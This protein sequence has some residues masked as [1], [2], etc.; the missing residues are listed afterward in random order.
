MAMAEANDPHKWLEE[1]LGDEPLAWVKSKNDEVIAAVGDP[2]TTEAYKRILAIL[3]SK[4]KIPNLFRIGGPDG[5]FYNF[6]QDDKHVQGIWRKTT[7]ASYKSGSPEW[8][9]VIDVDAL[10]PPTTDT[11]KTWVWHGSTLLDDGPGTSVDRAIIA[12]S[13]GGSDAD[14]R[15]EF[16]LVSERFIDASEGGF[17]MPTAA[18]TQLGWRSRNEVLVGT[19]FG[20]DGSTLTDSGYPRVVK[21][22][23]RGTPIEAAEV[24]FEGEQTDVAASQYAYHDRGFVHEFQLR[25]ITFYTSKYR[26]RLLTVD[27][28]RNTSAAAETTPFADVHI[29][30]DAELGTFGNAALV[31]LRSDWQP[32]GCTKTFTAGALLSVPMPSV[33]REDWSQV[34]ALFEPT[35]SRSLNERTETKDYVVL[36]ILEDVRTSLEFWKHEDGVWSKQTAEGADAIKVGEGVSVEN[37]S[38]RADE[39]NLV[40]LTRDGFLIPDTQEMASAEDG[41]T[42]TE[43]LRSKPAMFD[44]TGLCVEQFFATSVD[45][46]RVPYFVMRPAALVLDGTAP[47]IVDAY[48][49]FEIPMLPYYSGAVGAAWLERGGV[50]VIANIRGGGE[51][52]PTWHQAALKEKRHKA[53]E[54]VEAVAQDLIARK[55]SSPPHMGVIGGSNGGLMVGNMLTRPLASSLFGAAVCQVPLLDMKVYSKLLAGASWMG[56]YGNPDTDDWKFLRTFSAYHLLR[57]DCLGLPEDGQ[58]RVNNAA[59]RCPKVLFTTS[60]R[61]DRV[62]PGHARKMVRALQ[63]EATREVAPIVYYWENIEGGHGGAADNKQRAHMWGLTYA[64]LAQHLGLP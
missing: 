8:S 39:D 49:G 48:G 32:P 28:I 5:L 14:T 9:T 7:L 61:D 36:N 20:G 24:V 33:M 22:W 38:R 23:R 1:V 54:D 26:Y 16:D 31:T 47:T 56:E 45:G 58:P 13:P 46:T 27:A 19:D 30:E 55:I 57:H 64:F 52:G 11:A 3:D 59:W 15:R 40:W 6:W 25:S 41:C 50:K 62:H 2:T 12:L 4:D 21:S 63:E 37:L 18:K 29:P 60:T 34:T 44:A 43:T 35:P 17:D 42:L 53:Y 51:Y 10:A